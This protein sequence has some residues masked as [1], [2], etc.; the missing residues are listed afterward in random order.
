MSPKDSL[1]P[2]GLSGLDEGNGQ[3]RADLVTVKRVRGKGKLCLDK[4]EEEKRRGPWALLATLLKGEV[5]NE[6]APS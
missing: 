6:S 1:G 3:C 5:S 2:R 4:E